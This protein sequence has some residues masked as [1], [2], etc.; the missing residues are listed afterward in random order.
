MGL[1]LRLEGRFAFFAGQEAVREHRVRFVVAAALA[2]GL[3]QRAHERFRHVS[4]PGSASS[5]L[6]AGRCWCAE[7]MV[8]VIGSRDAAANLQGLR[9]RNKILRSILNRPLA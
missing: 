3:H 6:R 5:S 4:G 1:F 2:E 7:L 9:A 8:H